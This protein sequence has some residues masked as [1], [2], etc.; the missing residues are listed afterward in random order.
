MRVFLATWPS[1]GVMVAVR[2]RP[3][4]PIKDSSTT[5][6]IENVKVQSRITQWICHLRW[7]NSWYHLETVPLYVYSNGYT[8]AQKQLLSFSRNWNLWW[9][10]TQLRIE[11]PDS[12]TNMTS[13]FTTAILL[14]T[15]CRKALSFRSFCYQRNSQ[16]VIPGAK[17]DQRK[18]VASLDEHIYQYNE[19]W[20]AKS[21]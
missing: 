11:I 4:V 12:D 19:K 7:S 1:W 9:I 17:L 15:F 10:V 2:N 6:N 14:T 3:Q 18:E 5:D 8:S 16:V 21:H 20:W 13:G